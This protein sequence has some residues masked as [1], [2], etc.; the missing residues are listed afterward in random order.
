MRRE[1][2][3]RVFAKKADFNAIAKKYN[4]DPVTA[5]IIR[6]RDICTDEEIDEFL[7]PD[8]KQLHSPFL[9]KG[10]AE[11]VDLLDFKIAEGNRIRVIGDYDIDGTCAASILKIGLESVGAE[12]DVRI[13]ERL[14]DGYGLNINLVEEA[15]NDGIDTIITCDNGIAAADE[16]ARAKELGMTVIVT[17]HHEVPFEDTEDGKVFNLPSA[18]IVI[19][20]KQIDCEYPFKE[21]CGAAVAWKLMCALEVPEQILIQLIQLAAVAT[22]GDMMELFGENR[23][24]VKVGLEFINKYKCTDSY[25][26]VIGLDELIKA[27]GIAD[28]VIEGYHVGFILGPCIN[29]AGRLDTAMPVVELFTCEDRERARTLAE[30][31]YRLNVERKNMTDKVEETLYNEIEQKGYLKEKILVCYLHDCHQSIAGIVAGRI[32]ERYYKPTLVITDSSDGMATGSARSI[33]GFSIYDALNSTKDLLVKFGGHKLAAGFSLR[34]QDVDLLRERLNEFAADFVEVP[35]KLMIDVPMPLDYASEKIVNELE[36]LQ[37]FGNGN[38][39]PVFADREL[40]VVGVKVLG[41]KKNF[42]KLLLKTKCGNTKE[43]FRFINYGE[44]RIPVVGDKISIVYYP[45]INE[46]RGVRTLQFQISEMRIN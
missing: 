16:V 36:I 32:K 28:K 38:N 45:T 17:D 33:D 18:D 20:P 31:L 25:E 11:A 14:R 9:M 15:Y 21:L 23:V 12:V 43:A 8:L 13:P 35:E 6:N 46:F 39:K 37:P 19:D 40:T 4:I 7:H 27:T 42:L 10:I 3:W 41:E 1:K 5:R 24:I 26:Q 2:E 44:D 34:P 29:A 22:I 30:K